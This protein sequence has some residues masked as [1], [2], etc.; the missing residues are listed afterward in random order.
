MHALAVRTEDE[1]ALQIRMGRQAKDLQARLV[2]VE[3]ELE[4]ERQSRTKSDRARAEIQRELDDL[5]ERLDEIRSQVHT[6]EALFGDTQS[7]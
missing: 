3:D 5:N 7:L 4:N 1:K 2:E 6:F